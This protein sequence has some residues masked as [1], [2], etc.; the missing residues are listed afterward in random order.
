MQTETWRFGTNKELDQLFE[1][2]RETQYQNK[3]HHLWKN[4]SVDAFKECDAVSITFS[5]STPFFCS[6]ILKRDCWPDQTYRILNRLWK[7]TT[8]LK[9]LKRISPELGSMLHSQ[10]NWLQ[11]NTNYKLAFISREKDNWQ[12]WTVNNFIEHFG[13]NFNMDNYNYLTCNNVDN[14]SCWQKIIYYGNPSVLIDWT[15]R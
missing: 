11:A 7:P 12:Q 9:S 15:K 14:N 6:S 13:L 4:Y 1:S 10:L 3:K 5:N 8:R 2:L